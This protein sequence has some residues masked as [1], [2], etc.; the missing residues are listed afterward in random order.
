MRKTLLEIVQDILSD[1]D[2]EPV[3]ALGD[4][5]EAQ[6]I[7]TIVQDVFYDIVSQRE[8]PSH[9]EL[10]KLSP[11]S[12]VDYPTTFEY[13]EGVDRITKV[14]YDAGTPAQV[15]YREVCWMDPEDFLC[16]ADGV[17]S[18]T[19]LVQEKT[20]GT[21][22]RVWNNKHPRY[23]TSFDNKYIIMDGY[24]S[25]VDDTLQLSKIRAMGRKLPSFDKNDGEFVPDLDSSYFPYLI[26][27]AR[28]RSM[29]FFK[30]GTTTKAE[31]W[32][33]RNKVH[34]QNDRYKTIRKNRTTD[35]GR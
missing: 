27:E 3:N 31:Q 6:Q 19:T 11:L 8:V 28:S 4:S 16:M 24:D 5:N 2:S 25:S 9:N 29:D 26:S 1:M 15:E 35:Y 22:L 30:G 23:Y 33:R 32:A 20:S 21:Y 13:G 14:W 12:D 7:A 10:L 34:V 18:D 17:R